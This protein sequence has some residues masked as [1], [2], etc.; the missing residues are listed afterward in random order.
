MSQSVRVSSGALTWPLTPSALLLRKESLD[1]KGGE[2]EETLASMLHPEQQ[3]PAQG[4]SG[5]NET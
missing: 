2:H 5:Q 4:P 1:R 3:G